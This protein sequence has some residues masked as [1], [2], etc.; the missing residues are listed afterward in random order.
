MVFA[1][2]Y[3]L[4]ACSLMLPVAVAS[5]QMQVLPPVMF[6]ESADKAVPL[7]LAAMEADVQVTGFAARVR[8]TM[9]FWNPSNRP[10][11]GNVYI[12]LPAHATVSAYALDI[13]GAMVDGVAVPRERAR[14]VYQTVMARGIDPGIVEWTK[15]NVF[16]TRV[17]P[18]PALGIRTVRVEYVQLLDQNASGAFFR[19]PLAFKTRL[20]SFKLAVEVLDTTVQPLVTAGPFGAM[21]FS[22]W[23]QGFRMVREQKDISLEQDLVVQLPAGASKTVQIQTAADGTRYASWFGMKEQIDSK[24]A[25]AKPMAGTPAVFPD[26]LNIHMYVDMSASR[27]EADRE[28][29]YK[30]LRLFFGSRA[31]TAEL[32]VSI[33]RNRL[34]TSRAFTVRNGNIEAVLQ[35]LESQPFDGS[36][37]LRDL[38]KP[39]AACNFALLVSDGLSTQGTAAFEPGVPVFV[40]SGEPKFD[41]AKLSAMADASGGALVRLDSPE[42]AAQ[43]IGSPSFRFMGASV[44]SGTLGS[45]LPI[46]GSA[47]LSAGGSNLLGVVAIL[48]SDT[49]ELDLQFGYGPGQSVKIPVRFSTRDDSTAAESNGAYPDKPVFAILWAQSELARLSSRLDS[50]TPAMLE[51]MTALGTRFGLVSP[52]TSLLVLESLSQ[53]VEFKIEPPASLAEMRL[54]WKQAMDANAKDVQQQQGER[55]ESLVFQWNER[56]KWHNTSFSY[57]PAYRFVEPKAER[58]R[59]S[60]AAGAVAGSVAN[61]RDDL[62][63]NAPEA[64]APA[65]ALAADSDAKKSDAADGK[66]EDTVAEPALTIQ[67]WRPDTPW[68]RELETAVGTKAA[69]SQKAGKLG[70]SEAKIAYERY[71]VVRKQYLASPGFYLDCGDWFVSGGQLQLGMRIWSNLA[72]LDLENPGLLRIFAHRLEQNHDLQ[73]ALEVFEQ[74]LAMRPEEPQSHRDLALVLG[75]SG[76]YGRACTLLYEVA[77]A[78][79]DRTAGIEVIALMELNA[80]YP[81]ALAAKQRLPSIDKRLLKLLDADIRIVLNWDADL[82]DMDLWVVEPSGE[83]AYYGNQRTHIGGLVSEDVTGGYGPEEYVI[84]KAMK[85]QYAIKVNYYGN[86]NPELSGTVTLQVEVITNFGRSNE[87]R[88]MLTLQL[89]GASDTYTVGDIKF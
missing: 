52:G 82:S 75:K 5:A 53:Y 84:R 3:V 81:K 19:L 61:E 4:I 32:Q 71:L 21:D 13:Q 37:R 69:T 47:S 29:L 6:D 78:A 27:A 60:S 67:A 45:I 33:F 62:V 68:I 74:V 86:Q 76:E 66:P 39:A 36:T 73:A 80:L 54:A 64:P 34:D 51:A 42:L 23:R 16:K 40:L 87:K 25:V 10:R 79:W 15:G 85:G 17:F 30:T 49:A 11:A 70:D 18:V 41:A 77:R 12:P 7:A 72:E 24:L 89:K 35:F 63:H 83:K 65:R 44:R 57:P 22:S 50:E 55:I 2:I 26:S 8:L 59:E 14:R 56:V 48:E 31:K 58:E 9:T 46:A 43:Q 88:S 1:K 20:P 28:K 38:P